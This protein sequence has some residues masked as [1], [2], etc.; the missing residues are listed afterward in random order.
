[1]A[2]KTAKTSLKTG[3]CTDGLPVPPVGE[4]RCS[5]CDKHVSDKD[6]KTKGGW[7]DYDNWGKLGFIHVDCYEE[8]VKEERQLTK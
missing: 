7:F 1:M 5:K 8:N 3:W 6:Q 4:W 2:T